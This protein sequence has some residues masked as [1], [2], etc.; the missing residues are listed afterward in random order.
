[1]IK[2]LI[3]KK[4]LDLIIALAIKTIKNTKFNLISTK[5]DIEN[6]LN[7][8]LQ[9]VKNWSEEISFA[10]LKKSK[11]ISDVFIDLD[12]FVYPRR[13]RMDDKEVIDRIQLA[14]LFKIEKDHI[15][16]LG[17][18]G[19]GK[20]TSMKHICQSILLDEAFYPEIFDFPILIQLRD[21]NRLPKNTDSKK[22]LIF[23]TLFDILGF[24][25]QSKVD[26]DEEQTRKIKEKIVTEVLNKLK[27]LVIFDGFDELQFY[28]RRETVLHE[29]TQLTKYVET[30]RII[31]TSRTAD[32]HY[33]IE[34]LSVFEL[35]PLSDIQIE[36]FAHKWL[37]DRESSD[38]FLN[39]IKK[40]PFY[41][42]TIR[43][44]TIAHLCAIFERI[45]KIPDKP[46]TVY[47]K[48]INL[49]LEEWDEQKN[50]K[51]QSSYSSFEVDRKFEFLANLAYSLTT[52]NFNVSF[53][54]KDLE[55]AYFKIFQDFDLDK[56]E[57]IKVVTELESHTGLFVQAGYHQ[58]EFAHKSLQ[59]YLTAEYIVKLP[60]IPNQRGILIR[61]PEE[62]AIA[63]TISSSPSAYFVELVTN[64]FIP[65]SFNY[66]F[67]KSFINRLIVE[68][69]DFNFVEEV[70]IS[71]LQLY[72]Q[73][74]SSIYEEGTQLKLFYPDD[75]ISQFE[76]LIDTIFL[77]NTKDIINEHYRVTQT[78]IGESGH[79]ILLL[80]LIESKKTRYPKILYCR[81][82]FISRNP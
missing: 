17:Q 25:L 40:S 4:S 42:T 16:L 47:K 55:H 43:P 35:C 57:V 56:N 49:L 63:V 41:D 21:F 37:R 30:S 59:E 72:S 64:R 53:T 75:L 29:L 79:D 54:R 70:G 9:G 24:K 10:D 61:L 69:P 15:A 82:S 60:I 38:K 5:Q 12:L 46:K 74:L 23:T 7:T 44:L 50:I 32:F 51:R 33:S 31:V 45:G 11:A 68:K 66:K 27:A 13:I 2:E 52:S 39:A 18:P 14:N 67:I 80:N 65:N 28:N 1:M 20:T 8:H 22:S 36:Y 19:S 26:L 71:S 77:R 48:I 3:I 81:D 62:L 73:Y 6:S 58:Y 78:L 76:T 34:K